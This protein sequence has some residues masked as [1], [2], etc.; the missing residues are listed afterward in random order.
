MKIKNIKL[1]NFRCFEELVIEL[2]ERCNVIVGVNGAGKSTILDA[3]AISIGTYFAKIPTTYSL[4]IQKE[5]VLRKSYLTGS[6]ISTEYQFPVVISTEGIAN[7]EFIE[8][9][10]ELN[11]LKNKPTVKN[12]SNLIEV[13]QHS[14]WCN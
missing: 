10:R 8:W 1:K 14:E 6:I 9:S 5:D 4:P 13:G 7:G 2:N 11:G 12:A 3:L